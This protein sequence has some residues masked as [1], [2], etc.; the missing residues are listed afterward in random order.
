MRRHGLAVLTSGTRAPMTAQ[1]SAAASQPPVRSSRGVASKR[2]DLGGLGRGVGEAGGTLKRLNTAPTVASEHAKRFDLKALLG[3]QRDAGVTG[4]GGG[5]R[6]KKAGAIAK[7]PKL[8]QAAI[9]SLDV[10]RDDHAMVVDVEQL[11]QSQR[12][13]QQQRWRQRRRHKKNTASVCAFA[14]ASDSD[15]SSASP[16]VTAARPHLLVVASEDGQVSIWDCSPRNFTLPI[17]P[18]LRYVDTVQQKVCMLH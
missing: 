14:S 2:I 15:A 13:Q 12:V 17:A 9:A 8:S 10:D 11:R 3:K 7:R 18:G 16:T 6:G 1:S 5:A 4:T